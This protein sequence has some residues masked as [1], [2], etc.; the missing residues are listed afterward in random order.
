[1]NLVIYIFSWKRVS[2]NSVDIFNEIKKV[3]NKVYLLNCNENFKI[4]DE[5]VINL[6]D[7]YYFT[8]QFITAI[9][10]CFKNFPNHN[11]MT[12]T[13]DI[14][15]IADWNGIFERNLYAIEKLN[16]DVSAPNV[17]FTSHIKRNKLIQDNFWDVPNTDCT[18]WTIIPRIYKSI[19]TTGIDKWNKFGWGIDWLAIQYSKKNK[20]KVIRD[21]NHTISHPKDT[22]YENKEA[23]KEYKKLMELWCKTYYK[24]GIYT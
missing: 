9:D 22:G 17:D 24:D 1:M 8:K 14:S 18:V 19:L 13:G 15:P 4:E 20:L 6:D 3:T 5:N 10:H 16:T 21:Y 7:S 23:K 11:M 12:I 2:Q